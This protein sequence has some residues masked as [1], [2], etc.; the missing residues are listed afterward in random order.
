MFHVFMSVALYITLSLAPEYS[1]SVEFQIFYTDRPMFL[2]V[3]Q[4]D[5][6]DELLF[7]D[8]GAFLIRQTYSRRCP[9]DRFWR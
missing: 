8:R 3:V 5:T 7:L 9:I 4:L 6:L 2:S 1:R